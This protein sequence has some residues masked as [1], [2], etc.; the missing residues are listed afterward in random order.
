[1]GSAITIGKMQNGLAALSCDDLSIRV[2]DSETPGGRIVRELWGHSNRITD[3]VCSIVFSLIIGFLSHIDMDYFSIVGFNPTCLGL[4]YRL[5]HFCVASPL[6]CHCRCLL[7]FGRVSGD[8]PR[9]K[10]WNSL[11]VKS[12]TIP[13]YS[14]SSYQ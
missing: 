8:V 6:Y 2:V 7:A 5:P 14:C 12:I 13:D 11:V 4:A 3:F 1:M 10:S 9:R